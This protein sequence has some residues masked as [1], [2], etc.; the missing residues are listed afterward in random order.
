MSGKPDSQVGRCYDA[1]PSQ[2][3]LN[4]SATLH[5][6]SGREE[7]FS[8]Q[9]QIPLIFAKDVD[10]LHVSIAPTSVNLMLSTSGNEILQ[11]D[12]QC[13]S[14]MSSGESRSQLTRAWSAF[15]SGAVLAP[16]TSV[17]TADIAAA[18]PT[19]LASAF[20]SSRVTC[21]DACPQ[22]PIIA[23]AAQDRE[24]R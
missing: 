10:P 22:T 4:D 15:G 24:L 1:Q 9:Q 8:I 17:T 12:L 18:S 6:Q 16:A 13:L 3:H 11:L 2:Q 5:R 23:T 21:M 20:H 19:P 7:L 14:D